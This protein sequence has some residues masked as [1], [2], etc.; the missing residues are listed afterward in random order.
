MPKGGLPVLPYPYS[1]ILEAISDNDQAFFKEICSYQ[2]GIY[3]IESVKCYQSTSKETD[4]ATAIATI[5]HRTQRG[6]EEDG[7]SKVVRIDSHF[8]NQ[9]LYINKIVQGECVPSSSYF[10]ESYSSSI[11]ELSDN[12]SWTSL[13]IEDNDIIPFSNKVI[14]NIVIDESINNLEL[15]I[16]RTIYNGMVRLIMSPDLSELSNSKSINLTYGKGK[17][18]NITL[19]ANIPFYL[20]N[21][22]GIISRVYPIFD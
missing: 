18:I 12:A 17:S 3:I 19:E 9:I 11:V 6:T 4:D 7:L 10:T 21:E 13:N 16:N 2:E 22:Y 15:D 5:Y 1:V 20:K 14:T 8:Y